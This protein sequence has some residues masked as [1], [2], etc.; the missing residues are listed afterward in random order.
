MGTYQNLHRI[1]RAIETYLHPQS[2]T[3]IQCLHGIRV[4]YEYKQYKYS[5]IP[6]EEQLKERLLNL[7]YPI[8]MEN[9]QQTVHELMDTAI[10]L[11]VNVADVERTFQLNRDEYKNLNRTYEERQQI[12]RNIF[13]EYNEVKPKN[14]FDLKNISDDKQNVHH[15]SIND[16]IKKALV[17]LCN[18]YPSHSAFKEWDKWISILKDRNSWNTKNEKSIRFIKTN[19]SSFGIGITL[20][21]MFLSLCLLINK[22]ISKDDLLDRL[23]E[24]LADM[25]DTCSTGHMS[26]LINVLQGFSEEY[27]IT[28]DPEKYMKTWI[29]D[30]L[31]R[32]LSIAPDE[33]QE[34]ILEKTKPYIDYVN[35]ERDSFIKK[36]GYEHSIFIDKT[37]QEFINI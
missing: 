13:R 33:I 5:L 2:Y 14:I 22:H 24:E 18:E 19:P 30:T 28:L 34:G 11:R 31:N 36:F 8:L 6:T 32:K 26:R 23:N 1:N 15:S 4:L 27:S 10:Q 25:S 35:S 17:K 29:F 12:L 21:Q 3:H 37:I 16:N 7:S 9:Q 20:K